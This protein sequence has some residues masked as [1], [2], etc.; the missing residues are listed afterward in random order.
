MARNVAADIARLKQL[1]ASLGRRGRRVSG[2]STQMQS[3]VKRSEAEVNRQGF[4]EKIV[5]ARFDAGRGY[6]DGGMAWAPRKDPGDGHP[7]LR[8]TGRLLQAAMR[9]V[10]NT[11]NIIKVRWSIA[12]V[13]V[14]YGIYHQQGTGKM[15]RRPFLLDPSKGELVPAD[16]YCVRTIKRLLR[17]ALG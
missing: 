13:N 17:R 7:I 8:D 1:S 2:M 4:M 10:R 14:P 9:A 15:P 11:Y 16:N 12:R 3:I 6:A 5:Q